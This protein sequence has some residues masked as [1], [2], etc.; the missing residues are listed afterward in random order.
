[1]TCSNN[2]IIFKLQILSFPLF[3]S[4]YLKA[5]G[6]TCFLFSAQDF[7]LPF[8]DLF[9]S[10]KRSKKIID[11]PFDKI[12]KQWA[13]NLGK[14]RLHCIKIKRKGKTRKFYLQKIYIKGTQS[15]L[16]GNDFFPQQKTLFMLHI[17][18]KFSLLMGDMMRHKYK[19]IC[20][21][22]KVPERKN[23]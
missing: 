20:L 13:V 19:K 5:S 17:Q 2:D 12:L 9:I 6:N 10:V 4:L 1:M 23:R 18:L 3:I 15:N 7:F 11:A 16:K 8:F 22:R 21:G 14:A